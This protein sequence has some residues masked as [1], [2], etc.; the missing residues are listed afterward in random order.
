M[1]VGA[2]AKDK[3]KYRDEVEVVLRVL[4]QM[5]LFEHQLLMFECLGQFT[6]CFCNVSMLVFFKI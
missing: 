4:N 6:C 3:D 5:I 1:Q 2:K